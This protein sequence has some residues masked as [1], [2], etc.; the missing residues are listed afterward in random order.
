[1][2]ELDNIIAEAGKDSAEKSTPKVQSIDIS[3][4]GE[5]KKSHGEMMAEK[6]NACYA[7][8]DDA[9]LDAMSSPENMNRFLA[10]QS[11]FE[12][13]S[14]NNNLLIYMQMPD[15]V[16]LKDFDA[17]KKDNMGVK[18]GAKSIMILEPYTYTGADQQQHR[19]F[20]AKNV[21]DITAVNAPPEV[22]PQPKSYEAK[23]LIAALVHGSPVPVRKTEQQM[24][25]SAVYDVQNKVIYFKQ[26]LSFNE[27]FPAIAKALAHAEMAKGVEHYRTEEHEFAARCSANVLSQKYGVEASSVSIH[28]IPPKFADLESEELKKELSDIHGNVKEI[29]KRMYESFEKSNEKEQ[30]KPSKE[31]KNREER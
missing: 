8:I 24:S 17:W 18:K 20:N 29:S 4:G 26:G 5:G 7:M 12:R 2:N 10:V 19:A 21:F 25:E 27:I 22:Y 3:A 30:Q 23:K 31:N 16:R 9:C 15:A 14:L 1:M 6:R 28:S 13:Y 11:R